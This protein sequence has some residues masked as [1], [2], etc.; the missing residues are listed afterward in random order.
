MYKKIP[1]YIQYLG[2]Q[3]LTVFIYALLNRTVFYHFFAHT[4]NVSGELISDAFLIGI[5]FDI[6]LAVLLF[7]PLALFMLIVNT[8]FF[9]RSYC[10]K[11]SSFYVV[12]VYLI[13]TLFYLFDYGYYN[14]LDI[15][16]DATSLRFFDDIFI[17]TQ[18]LLE[19]YPIVEG[20]LLLLV[21]LF[22]VYR[23]NAYAYIKLT[24]KTGELTK[25]KKIGFGIALFLSL[26]FGVYNSF[27]HYPLRWSQAFFSKQNSVNQFALNPILYFF[28]SFAFRNT[29]FDEKATRDT[30]PV[31]ANFLK[32]SKSPLSYARTVSFSN[33]HAVKPNVVFVMME[34][35]GAAGMSAYGNPLKSTPVM[36]SLAEKSA[37]FTN[38]FVHK[39]GTAASVF[40]SVTGLPDIDRVKTASRNPLVIDQRILFDQFKG[41]KKLYFIGGSANWAN[42]RGLLQSNIVDLEL[43]EEGSY[44]VE[45][46]ADVWGMDDYELF[47][48]SD[49][50]LAKKHAENKPFV[51]YIQTASNHMP[52][53]V[54]DQKESYR[55]LTEETLDQE[56]FQKSGFKSI[57]QLNAL[58]YLD[59]NIEVFLKRAQ[60]SGY[61]DNTIFLFFGDHNTAMNPFDYMKRKEYA[62]GLSVH[63]VPFFIHAPNYVKPGVF[64]KYGNLFDVFPT[65]AG[66]A[67]I[68]HTNH[69]LGTDLLAPGRTR[70]AAFLYKKVSGEPAIHLLEDD[71]YISRTLTTNKTGLYRLN[72]SELVDVKDKNPTINQHMDSLVQAVY[73]SSKYL[74]YNNKKPLKK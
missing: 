40:A 51:A 32:L 1:N 33:T 58:R 69:T 34:S 8:K 22:G 66:V 26:S 71:F 64:E 19:S 17:S 38:F 54:P 23:I 30:Y 4:E 13:V 18:V 35:V 9:Q 60:K 11:L 31:I 47:K 12:T 42:I 29:G 74:Y 65:A 41:Y 15:R 36:D 21:F 63:H 49:K 14:Y 62:L 48:E 24:D 10:K 6:K 67:K 20:G 27:S 37:H 52:F 72:A 45:K 44:E 5:R 73:Q 28:D 3:I 61:Y 46:R 50:E 16:L 70:S 25:R 39:A 55:P 59:F 57:A 7:F 2:F 53:T 43:F 68:P 56:A